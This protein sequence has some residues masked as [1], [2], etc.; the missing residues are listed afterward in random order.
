MLILA[1]THERR[2]K[3][4][5]Y[6]DMLY[7]RRVDALVLATV[8]CEGVSV[9][10]FLTSKTPVVFIDNVPEL[11]GIDAITTDNEKAS[12][13]AIDYLF[14]HGHRRIQERKRILEDHRHLISLKF[15]DIFHFFLYKIHALK[16]YFSGNFC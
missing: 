8:D 16:Q 10:R 5:K 3:E 14:S 11:D 4:Q 1:D 12:K 15:T 9:E 7:T 13:L 6:L 2:D